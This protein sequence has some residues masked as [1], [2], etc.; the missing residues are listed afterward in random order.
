M[1]TRLQEKFCSASPAEYPNIC[2]SVACHAPTDDVLAC[3]GICHTNRPLCLTELKQ[4]FAKHAASPAP[5]SMLIWARMARAA[6][7]E[8]AQGADEAPTPL[9]DTFEWSTPGGAMLVMT[10]KDHPHLSLPVAVYPPLSSDM[11]SGCFH[12]HWI[13]EAL[14]FISMQAVECSF[15]ACVAVPRSTTPASRLN[16]INAITGLGALRVG[17]L[18]TAGLSGLCYLAHN[19]P[20]MMVGLA[21]AVSAFF[22]GL[23]YADELSTSDQGGKWSHLSNLAGPL[24]GAE[25]LLTGPLHQIFERALLGYHCCTMRLRANSALTAPSAQTLFLARF[26]DSTLPAFLDCFKCLEPESILPARASTWGTLL[27]NDVFDYVSDWLSGA[28]CKKHKIK[29]FVQP[30]QTACNKCLRSGVHCVPHNFAQKFMDEDAVWKAQASTMIDRLNTIVEQLLHHS[31][32]PGLADTHGPHALAEQD[33]Q[34]RTQTL[35]PLSTIHSESVGGNFTPEGP[36]VGLR[37]HHDDSDLVP[38]PMN[39]LYNLTD[40]NN[41]QLIRVDPTEANGPDFISQGVLSVSE[42][43]FLFDYYLCYINPLLWDG[44]LCS[45]RSLQDARQSSSLLVAVVLTVAALHIPNREQSLHATYG[46]FVSLMRGSCLLRCQNLDVIRALCIGAFYLTSLSWALCS[47]AV[48][49][50]TEM[51]LHKSSLQFARGS[52][53][54]YERVRLWYVLYVCDH[55]FALAYGR[56]PLMHEDPAIRNAE[57]LLE[58]GLSSKGDHSLVAQV[59][60]FRILASGYFMHG[61]D[62]DLELNGQDFERLKEFDIS[63]EQW[64]LEH[65]S[66]EEDSARVSPLPPAANILYYH[67]ARFQLNSVVL[68]GISARETSQDRAPSPEMSWDRQEAANIAIRTALSTTKLIV[69]NVALQKVLSWLPIFIHAMVAVCASFLL[70]MA[71]V[72]GEPDRTNDGT[73]NLPRDL[74]QYGLNFHTK[75]TLTDVERLVRV[76]GQVADNVSKRHVVRQVV[77]GLRELLQRFSPGQDVDTF[78]YSLRRR[79]EA[80]ST[81][82]NGPKRQDATGTIIDRDTQSQQHSSGVDQTH[83]DIPETDGEDMMQTDNI[84]LQDPFDLTGDLDWRFDNSFLF[85]IEGI[86]P[87]LAFL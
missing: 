79:N 28:E 25:T 82:G 54:S 47:R 67:L 8:P 84:R 51:N 71:V 63:V 50:A 39:N 9:S 56:P 33:H 29:C 62:P 46:A 81:A 13:E 18:A 15:E 72:F 11:A 2:P 49:V 1:T 10:G 61:C 5:Y 75:M 38:L 65:Q 3:D 34:P 70:K 16:Q 22:N 77:T 20:D 7:G 48:R 52:L 53:E 68:R 69:D 14:G 83:L 45:H 6:L 76:L 19:K 32:L 4:T 31:N 23:A 44:M 85:G 55:Q 58:S 35:S 59:K 86:D 17:N 66:K 73:L 27:S 64:R 43:K 87:E 40:P 78:R 60:L 42:A 37:G 24:L 36:S 12:P 21:R 74:A 80:S 26:Y 41:S 57:K 30:G